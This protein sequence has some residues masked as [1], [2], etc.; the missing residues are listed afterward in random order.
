MFFH[1]KFSFK[2][3]YYIFNQL[4]NG[5]LSGELTQWLEKEFPIKELE[6]DKEKA[7]HECSKLIPTFADIIRL[8]K[9][10][11]KGYS[12]EKN[13]HKIIVPCEKFTDELTKLINSTFI[14]SAIKA[15]IILTWDHVIKKYLKEALRLSDFFGVQVAIVLLGDINVELEN[16]GIK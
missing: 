4:L 1:L 9:R 10:E 3:N 16:A 14:D 7:F 8:Y 13:W 6:R 5:Q 11:C 2:V 15:M 12:L